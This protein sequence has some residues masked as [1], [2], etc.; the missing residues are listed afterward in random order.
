MYGKKWSQPANSLTGF[1]PSVTGRVL[2]LVGFGL[3]EDNWETSLD[4]QRK[5]AQLHLSM[6]RWRDRRL[7]W[8]TWRYGKYNSVVLQ[9]GFYDSGPFDDRTSIWSEGCC[10]SF[11]EF[12]IKATAYR[13]FMLKTQAF[14]KLVSCIQKWLKLDSMH[15]LSYL[16]T[17]YELPTGGSLPYL[18]WHCW[19][20]TSGRRTDKT[21]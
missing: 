15:R 21:C 13:N 8:Q 14:R 4:W 9:A 18:I 3:L 17:V 10:E 20:V 6:S 12:V 5:A 11:C 16:L 7:C 1:P 19:I 2:F